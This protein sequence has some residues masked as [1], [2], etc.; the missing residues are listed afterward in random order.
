ME[1]PIN[2]TLFTKID[3]VNSQ[4]NYVKK[5]DYILVNILIYICQRYQAVIK[6]QKSFCVGAGSEMIMNIFSV[7]EGRCFLR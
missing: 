5:L 1:L 2:T 6:L 3:N 4:N 7:R